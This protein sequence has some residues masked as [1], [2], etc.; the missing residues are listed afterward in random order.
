HLMACVVN[1]ADKDTR[2]IF[3]PEVAIG[4]RIAEAAEKRGLIVRPI[5]NLNVMSPPLTITRAEVDTLISTLRAAMEEVVEGL[6]KEGL[7]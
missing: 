6:Q 3:P 7:L 4:S 5:D 2:E 1:V